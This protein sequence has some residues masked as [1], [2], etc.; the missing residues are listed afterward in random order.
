MIYIASAVVNLY[1]AVPRE[2]PQSV[3]G[4]FW[5]NANDCGTR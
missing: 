2:T 3:N 4:C 5:A 1:S